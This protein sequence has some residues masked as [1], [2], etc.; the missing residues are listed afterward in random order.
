MSKVQVDLQNNQLIIF[1]LKGEL[2][3]QRQVLEV[4][5]NIEHAKV[6]SYLAI[7][8]ISY[9]ASYLLSPVHSNPVLARIAP[10]QSWQV[11]RCCQLRIEDVDQEKC[12]LLIE[13][14]QGLQRDDEFTSL[15]QI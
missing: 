2:N 14:D 7:T 8:P 9:Q 5:K 11:W 4:L 6:F 10:L 15:A 13:H 12:T 3:C 1:Y